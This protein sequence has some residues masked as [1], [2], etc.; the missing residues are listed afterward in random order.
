MSQPPHLSR[1]ALARL[2]LVLP[3][4]LSACASLAPTNEER[5]PV[6]F[7]HGN[8]DSAAMWLTT[9]WRFESNGWPRERLVALDMPYPLARDADDK[10][11]A[12]RSSA[13]E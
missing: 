3:L 11:Q 4:G 2:L 10:P 6:V 8:G 13:D 12:G 1:R 7:V 9:V 5:P